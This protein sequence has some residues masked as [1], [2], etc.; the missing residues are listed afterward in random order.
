MDREW[1]CELDGVVDGDWD[2]LDGS[3]GVDWESDWCGV[4]C[5]V[6]LG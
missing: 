5:R 4:G 6:P 1:E 2:E 3:W